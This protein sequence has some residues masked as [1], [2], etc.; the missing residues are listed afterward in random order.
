MQTYTDLTAGQLISV[1]ES[2]GYSIHQVLQLFLKLGIYISFFG[3]VETCCITSCIKLSGLGFAV[4]NLPY[5]LPIT[6]SGVLSCSA[7][8]LVRKFLKLND[9]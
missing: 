4:R 9:S 2:S 1:V 8:G 3:K 5:Y 6:C 7:I